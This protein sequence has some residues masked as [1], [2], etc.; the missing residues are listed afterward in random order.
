M[1]AADDTPCIPRREAASA[2]L[3][4][5]ALQEVHVALIR[6]DAGCSDSELYRPLAAAMER[7]TGWLRGIE[8]SGPFQQTGYEQWELVLAGPKVRHERMQC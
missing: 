2:E 8:E 3:E 4:L 5:D 1:L 6:A 7:L